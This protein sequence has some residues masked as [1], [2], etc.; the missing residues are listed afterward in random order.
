MRFA[1][2]PILAAIAS[3]LLALAAAFLNAC[4]QS[5]DTAEWT[6]EVK[7]SDGTLVTVWRKARAYSS[8]FPNS[9]RG[10]NID[11]ELKYEP[12]GVRA[13]RSSGSA[14]RRT[15][16]DPNGHFAGDNT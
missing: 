14:G 11:F 10:R 12:L 5:I 3:M 7:L 4:G 8:G 1:T 15:F 9:P 6:E 16:D 13:E 2:K